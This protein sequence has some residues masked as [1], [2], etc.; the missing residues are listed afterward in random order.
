MLNIQITTNATG[1]VGGDNWDMTSVQ[2]T[3]IGNGINRDLLGRTVGPYR[4]MGGS[5]PFMVYLP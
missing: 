1:G 5:L 4:F 2:I 3:G